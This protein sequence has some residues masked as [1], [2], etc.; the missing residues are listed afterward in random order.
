MISIFFVQDDLRR[1]RHHDSQV[2]GR[3]Q[4]HHREDHSIWQGKARL[5]L[6]KFSLS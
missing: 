2:E 5:S 6:I 1:Q 4:S 3:S